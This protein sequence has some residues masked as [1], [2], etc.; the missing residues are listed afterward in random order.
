MSDLTL[1][2]ANIYGN[3]D[4]RNGLSAR[5]RHVPGDR[6]QPLCRKLGIR[7]APALVDIR[8]SR[9]GSRPLTDG[10]VV[11]QRSV[12]KLLAEIQAR[13][14]RR[15][16]PEQLARDR[17]RRQERDI[18]A[19]AQRIRSMFPSIPEHE[20]HQIAAH[21]CL[22]G[23]GRVGRSTTADDPVY[24]AVVA[25]VRHRYTDYEERLDKL[26]EGPQS[27]EDR[28]WNRIEARNE[29]RNQIEDVLDQ[30]LKPSDDVAV[31]NLTGQ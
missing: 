14:H 21:A 6:L 16:S 25:H 31:L 28:Q 13:E 27:N 17:E 24:A 22:I 26:N 23:S 20:E 18:L 1:A 9:F 7:Y 4:I 30:W 3:V 10:V 8:K 2:I 15:R 29:V 12:G 19:F 11:S 5:Y